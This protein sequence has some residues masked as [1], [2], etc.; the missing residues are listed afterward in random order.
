MKKALIMWGGWLGHE[1]EQVGQ[2]FQN[3]LE[4]EGFKVHNTSKMDVLSDLENLKEYD[5][6]IPLWTMDEIKK[7]M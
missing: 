2:I 3:V 7:S 4:N 1:P 5:L 6:F